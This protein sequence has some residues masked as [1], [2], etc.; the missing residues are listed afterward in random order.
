[1]FSELYL[2]PVKDEEGLVSL[3]PRLEIGEYNGMY[4]TVNPM[5]HIFVFR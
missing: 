1:M 2:S 4:S 5:M 3:C